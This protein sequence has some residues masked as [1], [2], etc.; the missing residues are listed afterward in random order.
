MSL[1][2]P[3]NKNF[4]FRLFCILS[5]VVINFSCNRKIAIT[6][7]AIMLFKSDIFSTSIQLDI[8]SNIATKPCLIKFLY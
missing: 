2:F 1:T 5:P 6:N 7:N 3:C 4:H 8:L